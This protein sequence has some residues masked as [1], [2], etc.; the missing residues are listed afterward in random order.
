MISGIGGFGSIR[1]INPF[2]NDVRVAAAPQPGGVDADSLKQTFR[3]I[4]SLRKSL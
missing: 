2:E 4:V 1:V 3:D